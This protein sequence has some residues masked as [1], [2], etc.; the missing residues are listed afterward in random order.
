MNWL[1]LPPVWLVGTLCVGFGLD[2]LW[3][4]LG[5]DW[6]LTKGFGTG[7]IAVAFLFMLGAALMFLHGKTSVVPRREPSA[8]LQHGL[9][10]YS[11]N[12]I[13]LADALLLAGCLMRWDVLPA[14]ILVPLFMRVLT[15]RFIEDE[16]AG[17]RAK[18]GPEFEDWASRVRRWI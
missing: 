1:D 9:Y 17:L 18:F 8:F 2:H 5:F 10:R 15:K 14:L 12:P 7:L 6:A 11:R 16:E 13:Y 4:G 3:P